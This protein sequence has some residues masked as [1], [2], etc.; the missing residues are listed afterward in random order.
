MLWARD[1][2]IIK[3]AQVLPRLL[4]VWW[5]GYMRKCIITM[6]SGKDD[7]GCMMDANIGLFRGCTHLQRGPGQGLH[8]LP[9]F[10]GI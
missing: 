3:E 4:T 9:N 7:D 1:T 6:Q 2:K 5:G 10:P 8:L